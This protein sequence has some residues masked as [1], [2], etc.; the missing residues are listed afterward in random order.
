MLSTNLF[1][2]ESSENKELITEA[3]KSSLN[4]Y[5]PYSNFK[6]GAALLTYS[7]EIFS[8]CNVE[9]ASYG[10]TICAERNSIFRA[11]GSI[12]GDMKIKKIAIYTD[13]D[14]LATPCGA[15]RQVIQE[16]QRNSEII[17]SNGKDVKKFTMDELLPNPFDL[18]EFNGL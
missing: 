12:G 10:L 5:S 7:G 2:K 18:K 13:T 8:G 1:D 3:R 15:C 6:V 4:S 17:L 16:F 11:V 9:N 14:L